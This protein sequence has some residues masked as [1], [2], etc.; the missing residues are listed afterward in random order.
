MKDRA[1]VLPMAAA[2]ISLMAHVV[3]LLFVPYRA[4][5]LPEP[6]ARE[7]IPVRLLE[8]PPAARAP[9]IRQSVPRPLA[10]MPPAEA[11]RSESAEESSMEFAPP[12]EP[13]STPEP[14]PSPVPQG[15][16][17]M[18]TETKPVVGSEPAGAG[19]PTDAARPGAEIAAYQLILSTLRA[20]IVESIR[21]P[22]IA[23]ANG[24]E[25]TVVVAVRLDAAGRLE[26]A[27]VRRTS[28]H[29]VLDRA[30]AALL[31]KIT[32]V[33]NPLSQPITIEIPI[34]FELK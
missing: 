20:R 11:S 3:V 4:P 25:G 24:W 6:P 5:R 28:G 10:P 26:Q 16:G 8:L 30:A 18:P 33:A 34:A 1:S 12:E 15:A 19:A 29:E 21:Y 22:A 27:V 7:L 2:G 14:I 17:S 31:K 9:R 32:P 13:V 23:R